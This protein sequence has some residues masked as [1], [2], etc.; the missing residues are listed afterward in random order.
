MARRSGAP[1]AR[2]AR[3]GS[4]SRS[5]DARALRGAQ[6]ASA[7]R[8]AQLCA[9]DERGHAAVQ[10]PCALALVSAVTGD[11]GLHERIGDDHGERR[12][13]RRRRAAAA[14]AP[15]ALRA[16]QQHGRD[17][18]RARHADGLDPEGRAHRQARERRPAQARG[19]QRTHRRIQAGR[20]HE[21]EHAVGEQRVL[22]QQARAAEEGDRRGQ[23][24]EPRRRAG[25]RHRAVEQQAGRD[26]EQVLERDREAQAVAEQM[27]GGEE[28]RVTGRFLGVAEH[29]AGGRG[30]V[31]VRVPEAEESRAVGE[32]QPG[33][34]RD[35]A[36]EQRGDR[37]QRRPRG[38]VP[39][40]PTRG[41]V[42]GRATRAPAAAGNRR[43]CPLIRGQQRQS[44]R[45]RAARRGRFRSAEA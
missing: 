26:P 17:Q 1:P 18:H 25:A 10:V 44:T 6:E 15:R 20:L 45:W 43:R 5:G 21:R 4:S 33:P 16:Q 40:P 19:R 24:P 42:T 27:G 39:L 7:R 30:H 41:H 11:L 8:R 13:R 22:Q 23:Q 9:V 14:L 2:C 34:H 3:T 35:R 38:A 31:L 37:D 12:G 32:H 29:A 36:R 28:D